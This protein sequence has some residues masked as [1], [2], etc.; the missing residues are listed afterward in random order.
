MSA[1][2]RTVLVDADV[3]VRLAAIGAVDLLQTLPG[4]VWM[5]VP[6]DQEITS[7]PAATVLESAIDAGWLHI[8]APPADRYVQ[9]AARHLGRDVERV[10]YNGDIFLLA[11]ALA[12]PSVVVTDDAPLR[13]CC[14][15]L[16]I[17]VAGTVAI[18][19][20]AVERGPY[21]PLQATGQ[22]FALDEIGP[23]LGPPVRRAAEQLIA[24]AAGQKQLPDHAVTRPDGPASDDGR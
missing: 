8:A 9:H 6:V 3:F 16:S 1:G 23:R 18:I 22:L 7:R 2:P 14:R 17:P 21:T 15:A 4:D 24:E 11:Q 5:P 12:V 20:T 13:R 19:V 10:T